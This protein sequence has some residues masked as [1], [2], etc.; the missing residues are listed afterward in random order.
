MAVQ[1]NIIINML[2]KWAPKTLAESWDNTGLAVGSMQAQ[3]QKVLVALDVTK[4]VI[5]E[6]KEVGAEMIITH[7]P[8]LLFQ[9]FNSILAD[10]PLGSK[11]YQL[12]QHNICA[13]SMHTNLDIAQGGTNDVLAELIG[14]KNV[15]ILHQTVRETLWKLVV[16]LPE[17]YE[18]KVREALC[19]AGAGHVGHYSCCTFQSKGLGTFL[20]L[21]G[22]K[23]FIGSKE[24]LAVV[25]ECKLETI[26][27]ES[28]LQGA[29]DAMLSSHPYEEAAYDVFRVQQQGKAEGIGRI[30]DLPRS[31]PFEEF[32]S[33]LRDRLGLDSIRL[34]GNKSKLIGRVGLCTGSGAEFMQTAS[35]QGADAY[36]TGD[37]KFHEAQ[38]ALEMGLCVAD[39]THY[40]S[41]A[42]IVP[43]I[44]KY[45]QK[46]N[47][48]YNWD[49]TILQSKANGQTF[50]HQY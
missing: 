41:E 20:P 26:V 3:I 29:I 11:I 32:A 16:Y 42:L 31:M 2:E 36:I 19:S 21:E 48:F 13:Y 47:D 43:V 17:G 37:I 33:M 50:W 27:A 8:M 23:P 7:H 44:C 35:L 39:A 6:A 28:K 49:I 30:G 45:L 10:T 25:K 1:C 4:E 24:E 34:V 40:A 15:E 12:I 22:T 18:E 9:K 14:L 46:A 38:K 5:E